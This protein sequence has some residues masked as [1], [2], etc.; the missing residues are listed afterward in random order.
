MLYMMHSKQAQKSI[1]AWKV[2]PKYE[3]QDNVFIIKMKLTIQ[4]LNLR[5]A[6]K[7]ISL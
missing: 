2:D 6:N 1:F 7:L 5:S 3:L 4:L